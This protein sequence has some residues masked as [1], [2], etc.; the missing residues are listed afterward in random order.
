MHCKI[1]NSAE[2]KENRNTGRERGDYKC[3]NDKFRRRD[4]RKK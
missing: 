3:P 4:K 1:N 2:K